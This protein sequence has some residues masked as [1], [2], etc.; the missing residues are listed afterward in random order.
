LTFTAQ[1]ISV[2]VGIKPGNILNCENQVVSFKNVNSP[3]FRLRHFG[4]LKLLPSGAPLCYVRESAADTYP[5]T[6]SAILTA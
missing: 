1:N 5:F 4:R 2:C 6:S 3:S